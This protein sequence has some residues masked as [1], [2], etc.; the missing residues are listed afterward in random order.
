VAAAARII[1]MSRCRSRM[2]SSLL[3]LLNDILF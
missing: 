1:A 3:L 2:E